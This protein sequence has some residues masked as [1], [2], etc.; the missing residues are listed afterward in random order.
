MYNRF[1]LRGPTSGCNL[2][3][4]PRL[5]CCR[6]RW[7]HSSVSLASG[8][9]KWSSIKH[10][11]A[12]N[13]S[14]KNK[15]FSQ[16]AQ[17]ISLAVKQGG[18]ADPSLNIRLATA[19]EQ[20]QRY[21]VT[22][23]VVE[24]AIRKGAG[25]SAPGEKPSES[26]LYEGIGPGGMA[27]VVEALTD[28][29]NRTISLVRSVFNKAGG[30]MTPI[31]Y[32]FAKRGYVNVLCPKGMDEEQVVMAILD[33]D[34]VEDYSKGSDIEASEKQDYD[35]SFT[36]FTN[37]SDA[38][39]VAQKLQETKLHV[40]DV[41]VEYKAQDAIMETLKEEELKA[42]DALERNLLEIEEVTDVYTN[43]L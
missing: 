33:V 35:S 27:Y 20:A 31:L 5:R 34:G 29:K 23:K 43:R 8:H 3:Y 32:C 36:V 14:Q 7:L 18:S 4:L 24:N 28:N 38:N 12:K 42:N 41:G 2:G 1:V 22:K 16:F 9:N 10:D 40:S 6:Q 15:L 39:K 37:P 26:C 25:I 21:N 19:L 30:A 13:D 17:R 11:K